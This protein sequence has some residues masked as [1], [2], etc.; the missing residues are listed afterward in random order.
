VLEIRN[1]GVD[2]V[3]TGGGYG[4]VGMEERVT[5]L[6]GSLDAGPE[7]DHRWRTTARLPLRAEEG[8]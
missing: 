7:P 3:R 2:G 8:A 4:L 6:G 1:N 5:A